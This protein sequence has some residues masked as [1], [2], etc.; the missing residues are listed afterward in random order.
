LNSNIAG[1]STG[2]IILSF[3]ANTTAGTVYINLSG[4]ENSQVYTLYRNSNVV[5]S[6]TSSAGG[7]LAVTNSA[8]SEHD[9]DIKK[10]D[11]SGTR[12]VQ[13]R[14]T[15]DLL[16]STYTRGVGTISQF[17]IIMVFLAL[18]VSVMFLS[19]MRKGGY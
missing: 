4:L 6:F 5:S 19:M 12:Q 15:H 17:A 11:T 18:G 16:G 1:A 2:D 8:W 14:Y 3:S 9:F 10:G 7:V 13:V